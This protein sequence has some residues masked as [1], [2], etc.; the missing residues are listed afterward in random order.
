MMHRCPDT[1][2]AREVCRMTY[3]PGAP[4]WVLGSVEPRR[5]QRFAGE[6]VGPD[7]YDEFAGLDYVVCVYEL[8]SRYDHGWWG[9]MAQQLTP[10]TDGV[11]P[12]YWLTETVEAS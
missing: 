10:R 6:V 11:L 4:V 3:H 1:I 5:G 9:A 2:G 8:E 7:G 12:R